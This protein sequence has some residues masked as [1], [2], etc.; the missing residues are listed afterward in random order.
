MLF[1]KNIGPTGERKFPHFMM[2]TAA[3]IKPVSILLATM[4]LAACTLFELRDAEESDAAT[5][6]CP[7]VYNPD[8][9]IQN[10]QR[11]V[12][13]LNPSCYF[14][15]FVDSTY[16][17]EFQFIPEAGFQDSPLFGDWTAQREYEFLTAL[18]QYYSDDYEGREHLL[19]LSNGVLVELGDSATYHADYQLEMFQ[20][21]SL[22]NY[23]G[24]IHLKLSRQ[25]TFQRWAIYYWEDQSVPATGSWTELKAMMIVQ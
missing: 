1:C 3:G 11:S 12:S 19:T 2:L 17:Q 7:P 5:N 18:Q 10:F 24:S 8:D 21:D 14:E 20:E 16:L 13:L 23:I 4:L 22:R 25:S 6:L 15:S 9:V